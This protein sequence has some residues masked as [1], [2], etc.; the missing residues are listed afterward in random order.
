MRQ[1]VTQSTFLQI[2]LEFFIER[3]QRPLIK[4]LKFSL[5]AS[6]LVMY[7]IHGASVTLSRVHLNGVRIGP[8][9]GI[10]GGLKIESQ[11]HQYQVSRFIRSKQ[12][13]SI[14]AV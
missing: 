11:M 14:P 2:F 4:L 9:I 13:R 10:H 1:T 12:L 3:S 5:L 7:P 8:I 6:R